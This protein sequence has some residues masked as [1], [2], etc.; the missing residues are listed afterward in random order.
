MWSHVWSHEPACGLMEQAI[1]WRRKGALSC[2]HVH[3]KQ[4]VAA[5]QQGWDSFQAW[6]E[7]HANGIV[8]CSTC[9]FLQD[10]DGSLAQL[11]EALT[12]VLARPKGYRLFPTPGASKLNLCAAQ[13]DLVARGKP[14]EFYS[15]DTLP[16]SRQEMQIRLCLKSLPMVTELRGSSLWQ[17]PWLGMISQKVAI[18][19]WGGGQCFQMPRLRKVFT[20]PNA[21]SL[22][23]QA[24]VAGKHLTWHVLQHR[25]A[26]GVSPRSPQLRPQ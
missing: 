1:F 16:P 25:I 18:I 21:D 17:F 15:Q 8:S 6:L 20:Q 24:L 23:F 14:G 11:R 12:G 22:P 5:S 3:L 13:A 4:S 26:P 7:A 2:R 19:C 10:Q 9:C